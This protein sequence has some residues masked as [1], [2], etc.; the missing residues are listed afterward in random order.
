MGNFK[1]YVADEEDMKICV[2]EGSMNEKPNR[3]GH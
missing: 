3:M 1:T 2:A